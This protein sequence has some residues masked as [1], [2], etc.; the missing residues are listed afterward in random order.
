MSELVLHRSPLGGVGAMVAR[1]L[2]L[3]RRNPDALLTSLLLPVMLMLVFVYLFGGAIQTGTHYVEYV[4]P[5]VLL[6]CAGFG[7]AMTAVSVC[8]DMSGG[9]IDR[10]RSMDIGA[11]TFLSGHVAASA[12]RNGLS[13]VL[14]VGVGL[15]A[16]FRSHSSPLAWL[17][18]AG[19]LLAFIVAISWLSAAVGTLTTSVEAANGF[20][21][22]TMF[23][24]YASSAFVPIDTMPHWLRGFAEYQ[25]CTPIIESLRGLL[26]GGPVG[27]H[28][29][30]SLVWCGGLLVA[31][32]ALSRVTFR[33]RT[34]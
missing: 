13:A 19:I 18:A 27:A 24:T 22:V 29:W 20:T 9:I 30:Q 28:A 1:S 7:S 3:T 12:L 34:A 10:F 2:R 15:A 16:G 14:V 5:G 4:V 8:Q 11:P 21:F 23:A 33:R 17:A 26:V 25:P 32:I 6:L 31:S